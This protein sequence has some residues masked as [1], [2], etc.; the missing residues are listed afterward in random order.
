MSV[1][2]FIQML[3]AENITVTPMRTNAGEVYHSFQTNW[4]N[5]MGRR[6]KYS[7]TRLGLSDKSY[8]LL[9][10]MPL[11]D[12]LNRKQIR[13]FVQ[14][15]KSYG[16]PAKLLPKME[17][18]LQKCPSHEDINNAFEEAHDAWDGAYMA[19]CLNELLGLGPW[20]TEIAFQHAKAKAQ[21]AHKLLEAKKHGPS[22]A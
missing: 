10:Q 22:L 13:R 4:Q 20:F 5:R 11:N 1:K 19:A 7:S 14:I 16:Y 9:S 21:V 3:K 15:L 6:L 2:Q 18:L 8:D 12:P 17:D